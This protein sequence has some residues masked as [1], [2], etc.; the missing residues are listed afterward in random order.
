M[1]DISLILFKKYFGSEW[2]L[3]GNDYDTLNWLSDSKKP[4]KKELEELWPEVQEEIAKEDVEKLRKQ[5]YQEI[6]D[7]IFFKY[8]AGES[9]EE[10]WMAARQSVKDSY[11]YHESEVE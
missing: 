4:T 10:E 5:A 8:Q 1:I 3:S 9:T 7:P 6:A 2:T 11:P